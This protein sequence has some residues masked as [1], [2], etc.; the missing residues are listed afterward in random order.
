MNTT[1]IFITCG[2]VAYVAYAYYD[3]LDSFNDLFQDT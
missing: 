2:I 3:S 1:L